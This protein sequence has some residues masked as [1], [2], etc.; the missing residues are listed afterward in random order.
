VG[1]DVGASVTDAILLIGVVLRASRVLR[2][3]QVLISRQWPLVRANYLLIA[4]LALPV[5]LPHLIEFL[6]TIYAELL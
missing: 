4:D 5:L 3:C 2:R 1:L 6:S